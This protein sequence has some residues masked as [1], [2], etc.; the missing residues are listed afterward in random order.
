MT[1]NPEERSTKFE[2]DGATGIIADEGE[3]TGEARWSY[4][5]F[6]RVRSFRGS[7]RSRHEDLTAARRVHA[8]RSHACP[9][10]S[11][12]HVKVVPTRCVRV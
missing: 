7:I 6:D 10:P 2:R 3:S 11:T 4:G 8:C 9:S 5:G 12:R 1:A